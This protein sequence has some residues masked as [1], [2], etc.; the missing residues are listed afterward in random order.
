[1]NSVGYRS[2]FW[3]IA[4]TD[5]DVDDQPGV[6][7]SFKTVTDRLH[8]GAVILLHSCSTDNV[9]ILGDFIDYAIEQ[10]YTFRSLDQYEYWK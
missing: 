8:P 6:E 4:H 7:K 9:A 10:G 2:V 5:W 1:M 3:S